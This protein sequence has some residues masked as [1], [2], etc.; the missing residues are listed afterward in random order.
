MFTAWNVLPDA[1]A[2]V[3]NIAADSRARLKPLNR[4]A[5]NII[6]TPSIC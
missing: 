3:G 5:I 4:L 1:S 2:A 6:T